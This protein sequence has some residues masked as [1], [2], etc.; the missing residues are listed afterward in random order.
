MS[1]PEIKS[2]NEYAGW[3]VVEIFGHQK[4]AGFVTTQAFGQAVMFRIDVPE[5]E[6]RER[7]TERDEYH[8][9]WGYLKPGTKVKEKSIPGFSKLFG[10]ASI[11]SIT[12]CTEQ[13]ARDA[14]EKMQERPLIVLAMPDGKPPQ[15]LIEA[16]AA[17]GAPD[18]FGDAPNGEDEDE[19]PDCGR[20]QSYCRCP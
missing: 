13:V 10:V 4:Y 7:W 6:E 18:L 14:V 15:K 2:Q 19:C 17:A 3:A 11:F 12:P 5:L 1:D 16:R 8:A 9:Q 20:L